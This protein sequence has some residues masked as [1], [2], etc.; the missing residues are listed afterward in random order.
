[1]NTLL[2]AKI[3][4]FLYFL[5]TIIFFFQTQDYEL[6]DFKIVMSG[7]RVGRESCHDSAIKLF[8]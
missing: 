3:Q 4:D 7:G 6:N 8:G 2:Y 1:M 5:Q